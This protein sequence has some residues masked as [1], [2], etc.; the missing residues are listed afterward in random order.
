VLQDFMLNVSGRRGVFELAPVSATLSG[1]GIKGVCRID[2]TGKEP[3][4]GITFKFEGVQFGPL[5]RALFGRDVVEG[6]ADGGV[7][8]V[9]WGDR[10]QK[11][12]KTMDAS[13]E[14]AMRDGA[15]KGID[16]A[17]LLSAAEGDIDAVVGPGDVLKTPFAAFEGRFRIDQARLH[18]PHASLASPALGITASGTADLIAHTLD[19]RISAKDARQATELSGQKQAVKPAQVAVKGSFSS[20]LII[21]RAPDAGPE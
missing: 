7:E 16:L 2:V 21:A 18:T 20:P 6:A 1:G 19:F 4:G 5:S 14:I 3:H 12:V 11:V 15:I 17:A 10:W 9:A 13:G 8:A